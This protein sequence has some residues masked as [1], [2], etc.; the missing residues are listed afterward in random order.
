M[1]PALL[2]TS[3]PDQLK[4]PP[5]L[6]TAPVAYDAMIVLDAALLPTN[7]PAASFVFDVVLLTDA[8][9]YAETIVPP[10]L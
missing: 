7:P 9:E 2:P 6:L 8:E 3:P 5:L 1:E 10:L 4:V